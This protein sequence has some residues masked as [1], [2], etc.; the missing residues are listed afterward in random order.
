M[1]V[2]NADFAFKFLLGVIITLFS[3]FDGEQTAL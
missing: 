2:M 1:V 3:G